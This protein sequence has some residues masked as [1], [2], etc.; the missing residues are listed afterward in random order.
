MIDKKSLRIVYMGTPDFAVEPL[1]ALINNDYNIVGVITNY[2]KPSGRGQRIKESAVKVF[3]SENNLKVLQPQNLKAPEFLEELKT[4]NADLQIIV[5]FRMLPEVV[6]NMPHLGTFNLHGSLLPQYRGAAPINWAVIN[7]DK[8]TGTTT[9]FLEHKIDTGNI[10][11]QNKIEIL[12]NDT[13]G[14]VHDKLMYSGANL[15]VETVDRIISEGVISTPQNINNVIELKSAPK[16]FKED[17]KIN[18][19]D[20]CKII[21]NKIRGLSPYPTAWSEFIYENEKEISFKI[22]ES[23]FEESIH[24]IKIG[25]II[26]DNKTYIKVAVKNGYVLIKEIQ[27]AGKKRMNIGDFLRGYQNIDKL[28][29]KYKN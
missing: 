9:F 3:A 12:D 2:N 10:I 14:T 29:I 23:E 22:F 21:Y 20:D 13:A 5:A 24:E 26:T 19:D 15:V 17:C 1:K 27:I 6:W 18:W 25:T 11:M 28:T 8:E 16:I 7:G 4:L